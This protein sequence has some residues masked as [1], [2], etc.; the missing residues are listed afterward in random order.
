M[1]HPQGPGTEENT[2]PSTQRFVTDVIMCREMYGSVKDRI[3][4]VSNPLPLAIAFC[5]R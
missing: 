4:I 2:D 5:M 3:N 1:R